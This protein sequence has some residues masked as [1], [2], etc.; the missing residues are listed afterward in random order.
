MLMYQ[1]SNAFATNQNRD[2]HMQHLMNEFKEKPI[3]NAQQM[4]L[5]MMGIQVGDQYMLHVREQ[6]RL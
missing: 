3:I 5:N 6:E 2:Y 4:Q 1:Q